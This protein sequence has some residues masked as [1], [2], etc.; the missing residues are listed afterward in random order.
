MKREVI[1][2][3]VFYQIAKSGIARVWTKLLE[4]WVVTGWAENII[5]IDRAKTAER[6]PGVCYRDAPAFGYNDQAKDRKLL[7]DIC[8]ESGARVFTSTYYTFPLR[9]PSLMMVHDMIPEVLGWDLTNPMWK[10]KQEAMAYATSFVAVSNNTA[11]DLRRW[12][13]CGSRKVDLALLGCDFS[14]ATSFEVDAFRVRYGIDK[15]YFLLVGNR[16]DYKNGIL[17][18]KAFEKLGAD[19]SK[20]MIICSGG[21]G[22]DPDMAA[23]IGG[24]QVK[25]GF[26]DDDAMRCA[27]AGAIALVYPSIYEGF[28]LPVLE[29]MACG[30][31]VITSDAASIPEVGGDAPLYLK[32]T[33]NSVNELAEKLISV[34]NNDVRN[35][36]IDR[37]ISRAKSFKWQST[38]AV[39]QDCLQKVIGSE[40]VM[41]GNVRSASDCRL[42]RARTHAL[43]T[44]LILGKFQVTY[45]QCGECGAVQTEN[46]YWL[47]E[48]YKP[49]N[50]MFDTGQ[51][52]RSLVNAAVLNGLI[53]IAGIGGAARVVDYGCGSGLTVRAL[54]DVGVD[55]WGYDIYSKPRLCL[56][57]QT[58]SIRGFNVINLCEVI[59]HFDQP[60]ACFE[61]IFSE[62]P[63]MVIFQ[64]G[65]SDAVS[66]DW[67][68]LAPEHGQHIFFMSTKTLQWLGKK[69]GRVLFKV[70]GFWVMLSGELA[71]RVLDLDVGAIKPQ[72][73]HL[74]NSVISDLVA[75]MFSKPYF[76]AVQ[77][78][79]L[80]R[81]GVD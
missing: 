17:F 67:D 57:F 69:Y 6:V 34:Q 58:P 30:C 23:C 66:E 5:V 56:G 61:D 71:G 25:V 47:S 78:N 53:K 70:H 76:Y 60:G 45:E 36:A 43:F 33:E 49:E 79:V 7:Q 3:G 68:Y 16:S 50:E 59:E 51:V 80:L 75:D 20:Y 29:A 65:V 13:E 63:D 73:V 62:N 15:P 77:D 55:C 4:Q 39:V 22:I 44:K 54:R 19:R 74:L 48:A 8:D 10:Q 11:Q 12:I 27:Y 9:T 31:P 81:Q 18:F 28:G 32:L 46:P 41:G 40:S 52:T 37:G 72:H 26:L 64:T 38:A 21:G 2:D 35:A 1:I 14:P 24:G 42:C